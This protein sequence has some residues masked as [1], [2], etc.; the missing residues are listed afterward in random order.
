MSDRDFDLNK[1]IDELQKRLT[2]INGLEH[3]LSLK[4]WKDV[5][6]CF[7]D[8]MSRYA[9]SIQDLAL[10]A[11]KNAEEIKFKRHLMES[12][13]RILNAVKGQTSDKNVVK[14]RLKDLQLMMKN[15]LKGR[16][17]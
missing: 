2:E 7:A 6:Q 11:P 4:A 9:Q 5:E 17:K 16:L 13:G 8:E 14:S 10:D 15:I 1:E 12:L 3:L